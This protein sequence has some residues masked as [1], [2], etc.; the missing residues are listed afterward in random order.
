MNAHFLLQRTVP[1][2]KP[3]DPFGK[4]ISGISRKWFDAFKI[5]LAKR[6]GQ[7]LLVRAKCRQSF[8]RQGS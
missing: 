7:V 1:L 6:G 8:L 4:N 2:A 3:I 5:R